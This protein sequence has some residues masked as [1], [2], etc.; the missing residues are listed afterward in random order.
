MWKINM[1]VFEVEGMRE[2][3]LD[4]GWATPHVFKLFLFTIAF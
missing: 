1:E 4:I 2:R 3:S